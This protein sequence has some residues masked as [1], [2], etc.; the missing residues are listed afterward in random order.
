MATPAPGTRRAPYDAHYEPYVV[1]G[2]GA[3]A[4]GKSSYWTDATRST[5]ERIYYNA[6]LLRFDEEGRCVE[7][8]EYFLKGPDTAS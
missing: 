4:V 2:D 6:F 5:L 8:T 7:F 1:D 3:V